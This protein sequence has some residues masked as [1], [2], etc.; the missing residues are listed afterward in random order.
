MIDQA[1]ILMA[2][3]LGIASQKFGKITNS[4][5]TAMEDKK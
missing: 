1:G 2:Q 4:N 5:N 3:G